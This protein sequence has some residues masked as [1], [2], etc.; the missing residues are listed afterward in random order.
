MEAEECWSLVQNVCLCHQLLPSLAF[1]TVC[2]HEGQWLP[3]LCH[4]Q[5]YSIQ[6]HKV[7]TEDLGTCSY[8]SPPPPRLKY[9][10]SPLPLAFTAKIYMYSPPH[11][12][13]KFTCTLPRGAMHGVPPCSWKLCVCY[14]VTQ[15]MTHTVDG[16][17]S[18]PQFVVVKLISV[19]IA[20]CDV[21][22]HITRVQN[23]CPDSLL[24]H[25]RFKLAA[26]GEDKATFPVFLWWPCTQASLVVSSQQ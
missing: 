5:L 22:T 18:V 20:P 2:A 21:H 8:R 16:N 11:L 14:V 23:L 9:M 6:P 15:K 3:L 19:S 25:P 13:V 1:L 4:A 10:H 26:L 17:M 7:S 12:W 24:F